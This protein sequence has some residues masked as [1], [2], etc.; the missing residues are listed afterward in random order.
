MCQSLNVRELLLRRRGSKEKLPLVS[1]PSE[2]SETP[3]WRDD[4]KEQPSVP[5]FVIIFK[6]TQRGAFMPF[7]PYKLQLSHSCQYRRLIVRT[8][9]KVRVKILQ[10]GTFLYI[11]SLRCL[12]LQ[13]LTNLN[14]AFYAI[15]IIEFSLYKW[16]QVFWQALRFNQ[17]I[18][19]VQVMFKV[20]SL[21]LTSKQCLQKLLHFWRECS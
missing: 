2:F 9:K 5:I 19:A 3:Y 4:N 8:L 7:R 13:I 17:P 21:W 16:F 11:Q 6:F 14:A 18:G 12:S 20:R 10:N 1:W 15:F